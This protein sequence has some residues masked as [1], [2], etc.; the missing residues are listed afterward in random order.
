MP[1]LQT[2]ISHR[3]ACIHNRRPP[4][5]QFPAADCA[6]NLTYFTSSG[7][8]RRANR[9]TFI[10]RLPNVVRTSARRTKQ[11]TEVQR[12]IG[13]ALDFEPTGFAALPNKAYRLARIHF[14]NS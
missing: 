4:N 2:G 5:W 1:K 7:T 11:L 13:M 12:Q 6:S 8:I 10:K 14:F 9:Q 3:R